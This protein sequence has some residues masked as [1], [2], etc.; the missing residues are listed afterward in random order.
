[1]SFFSTAAGNFTWRLAHTDIGVH[2][3]PISGSA[4]I[5]QQQ[6]I[7]LYIQGGSGHVGHIDFEF[8]DATDSVSIVAVTWAG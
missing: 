3:N 7:I 4:A 6:Q 1:L 2:L 8:S 5:G